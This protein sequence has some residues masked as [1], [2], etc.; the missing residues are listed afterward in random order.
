MDLAFPHQ[1]KTCVGSTEVPIQV[2]TR[3]DKGRTTRSNRAS[4]A[5]CDER[6]G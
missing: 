3:I 4:L 1:H 2:L 6:C 5:G